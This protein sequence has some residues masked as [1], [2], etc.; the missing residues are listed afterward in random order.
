[1]RK[2]FVKQI[3]CLLLLLVTI[4][5]CQN[6]DITEENINIST[7]NRV[8]AKRVNFN[9]IKQNEKLKKSL[10]K[11]EKRLNY[12]KKTKVFS[13]IE[14][15]NNSF[16]ILTDEIIQIKTDDTEAY[17]FRI[18]TPT[19]SDSAF[20]NFVIEKYNDNDYMFFIYRYKKLK[21]KENAV[22]TYSMSKELVNSN[23]INLGDFDAIL[24]SKYAYDESS[25][26]LFEITFNEGCS[27]EYAEVIYCQGGGS[28]G[29]G[30][31]GTGDNGS[32]GDGDSEDDLYDSDFDG[33]SGGS[34]GSNTNSNNTST[35]GVL[36]N[37]VDSQIDVFFEQ[38]TNEQ[39]D[40]LN[41]NSSL[42]HE[43]RRFLGKNIENR[44]IEDTTQLFN[45]FNIAKDIID[46]ICNSS[47]PNLTFNDITTLVIES[48]D[49]PKINDIVKELKC[50]DLSA[51]AKMTIYSQQSIAGSRKVTANIG[52]TFIG[53]EQNGIIRSIGFY[54]D[55][56]GA[57]LL[58][59][60]SSELHDNSNSPYDVSIT[61]DIRATQFRETVNYITNYS[62]TYDLNNYN[63]TDFG[64]G[65]ALIGGLTLPKTIGKYG[66]LFK[67]RNPGDLGEDMREIILPASANRNLNGGTAP[68]RFGSCP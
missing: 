32:I 13:K 3:I 8:I 1:M 26:C 4:F 11:I 21:T 9:D 62:S 36:P 29:S 19:Y 50:F 38:L 43:V 5:S 66:I 33:Q 12:F 57:S 20:E 61:I 16:S 2:V 7:N 25:G 40:C 59:P 56:P 49:T 54:P 18:E 14:S 55:S 42:S 35:V 17:T 39:K 58:K 51:P 41:A 10:A 22:I 47:D 6:D 34:G 45:P 53:L 46:I 44:V 65:I 37:P 23:Q 52:H 63:C 67:G 24:V 15:N 48:F 31:S 64:I 27:C 30:G 60:Q 28:G 68:A